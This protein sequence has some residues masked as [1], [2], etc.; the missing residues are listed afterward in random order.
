MR[1][2]DRFERHEGERAPPSCFAAPMTTQPGPAARTARFHRFL[3]CSVFAGMKTEVV[4]L[5]ADLRDEESATPVPRPKPSQEKPLPAPSVPRR[6]RVE[7][8]D[9]R[10]VERQDHE[11]QHET[12]RPD[13]P[14]PGLHLG[15]RMRKT[16][17]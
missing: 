9:A 6:R 5:L 13:R 1:L 8:R 16:V 7:S 14:R 4:R 11:G 3:F 12:D 2:A 15:E 10:R 17:G